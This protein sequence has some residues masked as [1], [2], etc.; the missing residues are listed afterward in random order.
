[1]WWQT[2]GMDL[3]VKRTVRLTP[4]LAARLRECAA[5]NGRSENAEIVYRLRASLEGY[6]R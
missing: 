6:R 2:G 4:E 5:Q 3:R 1:M